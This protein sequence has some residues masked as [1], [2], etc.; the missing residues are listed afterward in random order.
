MT[1]GTHEAAGTSTIDRLANVVENFR[2]HYDKLTDVSY[3]A[4]IARTKDLALYTEYGN[5]LAAA[6]KM[7]DRI[8]AVT[9]AWEKIKEWAGLAA[10]PFIPV[11]IA[12]GLIAAVGGAIVSIQ[13]FMKRADIRLALDRD[14]ALTYEE[15][16]DQVERSTQ[17]TIGKA[18]DVAQLGL[19]A[20]LAFV[21]YQL[22]SRR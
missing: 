20:V 16:R 17:G 19:F 14:P 5:Q 9:G 4:A 22:F 13:A 18:L 3:G 15:A 2:A 11:A 12:L 8:E 6:E 10:I 1:L 7:K 21:A